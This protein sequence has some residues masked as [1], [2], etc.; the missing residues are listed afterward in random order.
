MQ[1][2]KLKRER[3]SWTVKPAT[4]KQLEEW[5]QTQ[6]ESVSRIID[7]VVEFAKAKGFGK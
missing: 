1:I 7:A 6:D 2:S 5:A 3:V 4:V